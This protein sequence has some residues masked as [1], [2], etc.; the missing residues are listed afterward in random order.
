MDDL[1]AYILLYIDY[2]YISII[3]PY[4]GMKKHAAEHQAWYH[5]LVLG[6]GECL[7]YSLPYYCGQ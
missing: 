1:E 5:R 7:Y 2:S 6:N 3:F 4:S